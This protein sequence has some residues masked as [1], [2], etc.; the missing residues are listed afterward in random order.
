MESLLVVGLAII[1]VP[2]L[3]ER[4]KVN[5][6]AGEV[7]TG[8]AFV[9]ILPGLTQEVWLERL[10]EFGLL[11]LMFEIGLDIDVERLKETLDDSLR[12]AVVSFFIPFILVFILIAALH[13]S[14]T[15][16]LIFAIGLSSTA[17]AVVSPLMR[18]KG[19]DS[20]VI[21]NAAMFAEMIGIS[22]LIAFVRG[23]DLGVNEVMTQAFAVL[24][25]ISFT[26]FIVPPLVE[27]LQI[28]DSKRVIRFETKLVLF[29]VIALAVISEHLGI[30][31]ATGAFL[32]GLFFSETT[33]RGMEL[34][35][36]IK[37]VF[38][39]LVPIFFFHIG[40]LIDPALLTPP[41]LGQATALAILVY[42]SRIVAFRYMAE[43]LGLAY[44]FR[45][46]NLFAPC[47]TITVTAAEIGR[48]L[49]VLPEEMFAMF[50][51]AGLLLTI[52]GP[53]V[54]DFLTR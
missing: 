10:A 9:L 24:G 17:L 7:L 39:L 27:R 14:L 54:S 25:F 15:V 33:H 48:N 45:K 13:G 42:L 28:L 11:V 18:R 43:P 50:I 23:R 53:F 32:A 2:P 49:A 22:L 44:S 36:R 6:R 1:V 35:E 30:H 34:E 26:I 46:I 47:I 29:I 3:L 21:K 4:L 41:L 40:T 12:Y 51:V 16:S 5:I 8:L 37:P 19:F 52:L 38:E 20:P 31:A